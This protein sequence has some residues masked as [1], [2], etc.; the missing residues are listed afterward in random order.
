MRP[1][2]RF[3][4]NILSGAFS[5]RFVVVSCG[6]GE[7]VSPVV[8]ALH[9]QPTKQNKK[10]NSYMSR[11]IGFSPRKPRHK[12]PLVFSSVCP[13]ISHAHNYYTYFTRPT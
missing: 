6:K 4:E 7:E 5:H 8:V 10:T 3:S 9:F 13:I 1:S 11:I 2:D 12:V